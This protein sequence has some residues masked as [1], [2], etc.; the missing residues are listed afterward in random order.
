VGEYDSFKPQD[1]LGHS[2]DGDD[3]PYIPGGGA[4][5]AMGYDVTEYGQPEQYT[6]YTGYGPGMAQTRY[7]HGPYDEPDMGLDLTHPWR[8]LE[9]PWK[10]LRGFW[11]RLFNR[12]GPVAVPAPVAAAAAAAPP[13]A[14]GWDYQ[15]AY[16]RAEHH[17][18]EE[19][20]PWWR[21]WERWGEGR[22]AWW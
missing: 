2:I 1:D 4:M 8:I 18:E 6:P 22:R 16:R 7:P 19:E 17:R 3:G 9:A 13:A 20:N 12:P 5:V 21:R 10:D 15:D 11:A 14:V